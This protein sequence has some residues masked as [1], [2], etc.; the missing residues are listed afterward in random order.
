MTKE[1]V[2]TELDGLESTIGQTLKIARQNQKLSEEQIAEQLNLSVYTIIDIESDNY[3]A[4]PVMTYVRGYIVSYCRILGL[5]ATEVLSKLETKKKGKKSIEKTENSTGSSS[6]FANKKALIAAAII[7]LAAIAVKV[8]Y[9]SIKSKQ[10]ATPTEEIVS[11]STEST[12]VQN[13]ES[14]TESQEILDVSE[15]SKEVSANIK[16][17]L[18]LKFN[19]VS[20]VD[21]QTEGKQKI[22]YKSFSKDETHSIKAKLPL[23]I[24]I[25]NAEAVTISYEGKLIDL[26]QYTKN[27]YAKFTLEK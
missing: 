26:A 27:G 9:S 4:L 1:T 5:D 23:N 24:F 19:A 6:L 21:I 10:V 18:E 22:V 12:K 20:W 13:T 11:E 17:V 3:D 7:A 8:T 2:Q 16:E 15:P 14:N 25:D